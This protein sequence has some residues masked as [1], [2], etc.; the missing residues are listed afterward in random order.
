MGWEAHRLNQSG[1]WACATEPHA[2][3]THGH[4]VPSRTREG[5]TVGYV[6]LVWLIGPWVQVMDFSF[7]TLGDE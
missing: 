2:R 4:E 6:W 3:G 5:C 7:I 1:S